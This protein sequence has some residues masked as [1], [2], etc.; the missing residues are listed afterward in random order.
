MNI[1]TKPAEGFDPHTWG[2]LTCPVCGESQLNATR[3]DGGPEEMP[4]VDDFYSPD[5]CMGY[6]CPTCACW[7]WWSGE[8]E[9]V[10]PLYPMRWPPPRACW[11]ETAI[12]NLIVAIWFEETPGWILQLH[13]ELRMATPEDLAD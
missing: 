1:P 12:S 11:S 10:S 4:G 2:H 6:L 9:D 8:I 7:T 5:V 3:M 13:P